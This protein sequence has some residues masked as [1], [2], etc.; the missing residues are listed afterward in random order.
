MS[1]SAQ[2]GDGREK[3]APAG[4]ERLIRN[5]KSVVVGDLQRPCAL[6]N[7]ANLTGPLHPTWSLLSAQPPAGV[8]KSAATRAILVCDR[9]A[10]SDSR[11]SGSQFGSLT[12]RARRSASSQ[13]ERHDR[14]CCVRREQSSG[15]RVFHH[16][17]V[18]VLSVEWD[19]PRVHERSSPGTG[20]TGRTRI[21]PDGVSFEGSWSAKS[22][23]SGSIIANRVAQAMPAVQ[24]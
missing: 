16:P 22:N 9:S 14:T 18:D 20:R 7:P 13:L 10:S 21:A 1:V 23:N 6:E 19:I 15:A 17:V 4:D 8:S 24:P 3:R 2:G 12:K 11:S 5:P